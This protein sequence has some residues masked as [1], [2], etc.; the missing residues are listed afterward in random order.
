MDRLIDEFPGYDWKY[1]EN[2]LEDD[3]SWN[4]APDLIHSLDILVVT[5]ASDNEVCDW[6][7]DKVRDSS[8]NAE[9]I[10]CAV[11]SD[12]KIIDSV[13]KPHESQDKSS[14]TIEEEA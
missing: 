2:D 3:K 1:C 9:W 11:F 6:M 5:H 10:I 13:L 4:D 8:D 12:E 14:E 7:Q